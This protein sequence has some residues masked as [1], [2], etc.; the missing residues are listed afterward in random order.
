M[1]NGRKVGRKAPLL[2]FL[3]PLPVGNK[4]LS[5]EADFQFDFLYGEAL[6]DWSF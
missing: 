6:R 2:L 1:M 5:L 4:I 3:L